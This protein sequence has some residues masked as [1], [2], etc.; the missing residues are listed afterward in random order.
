MGATAT[1]LFEQALEIRGGPRRFT[2]P[3]VVTTD[4]QPGAVTIGQLLARAHEAAQA[5]AAADC[6]VCG[7]A[8]SPHGR[9]ARCG[10]CGSRLS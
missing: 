6:P 8:M 3:E 10:D 9:E 7:A 1:T 5:R 4:R 2:Q